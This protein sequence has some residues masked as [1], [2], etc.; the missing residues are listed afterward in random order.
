MANREKRRRV[1]RGHRTRTTED[2]PP[3][4]SFGLRVRTVGPPDLCVTRIDTTSAP[5]PNL[6]ALGGWPLVLGHL[7]GGVDL[8]RAEAAAALTEVLDGNATPAQ[9]A[10]FVFGLRC[11]GE[12]VEEMTGLVAA[13]LAASERVVVPEGLADRLVDT[14]GTGGDRSGTI[15]VSTIAAL[16]V[17]GAGVPVCKHGGGRRPR[18]PVLL[19]SWRP[20]VWS[21]IWA[22]RGSCVVS[23]RRV[24]AFA[25]RLAIT[26]RCATPCPSAASWACRRPSTSSGRWPT[27]RGFGA[28]SSVSAIRRWRPGWPG[29]WPQGVPPTSSSCTAPT[30]STSCRRPGPQ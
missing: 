12:T 3:P 9:I 4:P 1:G 29:F 22:R 6:E 8:G 5:T 26:R 16:V 27:R 30:G 18:R 28:R 19:M 17:A 10:A 11:K 2:H 14:C 21:S 7:A 25:L 15:N 24:S 20:S 23:R 13:M